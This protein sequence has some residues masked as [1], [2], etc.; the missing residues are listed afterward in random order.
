VADALPE[1][2]FIPRCVRA[3]W[4]RPQALCPSICACLIGRRSVA[5][6]RLLRPS[7][8]VP[9]GPGAGTFL[10]RTQRLTSSRP[11]ADS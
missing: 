6:Q 1:E 2:P 11:G 10:A 7:S 5:R 9:N 4:S 3:Q 8:L